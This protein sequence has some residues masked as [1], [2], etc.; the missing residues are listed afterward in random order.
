MVHGSL[1]PANKTHDKNLSTLKGVVSLSSYT[2]VNAHFLCVIVHP[3]LYIF[4]IA[5]INTVNKSLGLLYVA[6]ISIVF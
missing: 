4:V 5:N 3:L 2:H 6:T 1:K